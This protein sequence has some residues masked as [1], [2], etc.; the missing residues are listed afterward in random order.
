MTTLPAAS[1]TAGANRLLLRAAGRAR[2]W[3]A[4]VAAA[5]LADA[6]AAVLLPYA[7]ARAIDAVP[8]G[9]AP[10]AAAVWPCVALVVASAVA[11]V[12]SELSTGCAAA[13][14]TAWLRHTLVR[15][16]L[17]VGPALRVPPGDVAG[18]V[19]GGAAEAGVA[20]AAAPEAAV[21]LV[22]AAG[23]LVALFLIDWR[24]AAAIA[25]A[26]PAIFLLLRAFVRDISATAHRYLTVQGTIA[27][28]LAEALAGCRTIAAAGTVD[29]ETVRVLEPLPGLR[30]EGETMWRVQGGIAARG[31]LALLLLQIA[32]VGVAG[33]ELAA[34][35]VS[36]GEL[37]AIV[38]YTGLAAGFGPVLTQVLRLGRARAGAARAAE[39]LALPAPGHGDETLASGPGRLDFR[40]VT[41]AGGT[42]DG[43][44]LTVPG[45][46]AVAVTG[47]SGTSELAALAG[48]LTDPDQGE[49]LLDGTPL[50]RLTRTELRREIGY[51]FA[52]PALFGG[53]VRDA[54]AFG[55]SS[56]P[57]A[58]LR[59][60]ARAARADDFIRRLPHGYQTPLADAPMS[61]GELQRM[62]LARAFAHAGRVLVLD[63]ATSSLDT[64]TELQITDALLHRLGDRTRLIITHRASTAA[65]ADLVAWLEDGRVRALA[66]HA[67][68]WRDP[69]YR[70]LFGGAG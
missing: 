41:A 68:L 21:G 56:P 46:L 12:L 45:G 19:V 1:P 15:H 22:P 28:R 8:P 29:R 60:S 24:V 2:G 69:D 65:R 40:G 25:V 14:S 54:L 18:R 44:D 11:E 48:R 50:P 64:V 59:E 67:K 49:V 17:A 52:R 70:G 30:A 33:M 7:L 32:A 23:A 43:L 38:Q 55:P 58:W 26:L 57:D 27:G 47:R 4:L 10:A 37:V 20:P 13:R 53:T 42:I 31:L 3:T 36:P 63:D 66:P 5:A 61:G 35:R 62:G 6:A 39:I 16:V 9:G 34:G 51:A